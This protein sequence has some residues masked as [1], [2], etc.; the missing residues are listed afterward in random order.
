MNPLSG[1]K[2]K[3]FRGPLAIAITANFKI[4]K[5]DAE[6]QVDEISGTSRIYKQSYFDTLFKETGI[7]L[8]NIVFYKDDTHYFIMTAKKNSLLT[9]GVLKQV[10]IRNVS[11]NFS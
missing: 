9:R 7:D 5:T 8:E 11:N 10:S 2:I 1:F 3:E 4:N 6:Q